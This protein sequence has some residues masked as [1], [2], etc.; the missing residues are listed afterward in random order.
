M[1]YLLA[2]IAT[3]ALLSSA[4]AEQEYGLS[5]P[6]AGAKRTTARIATATER[7]QGV[8]DAAMQ[9]V[10]ADYAAQK[11]RQGSRTEVKTVEEIATTYPGD[12]LQ[13]KIRNYI[14]ECYS[15]KHTVWVMLGGDVDVIPGI[16]MYSHLDVW[17]TDMYYSFLEQDWNEND[18]NRFGELYFSGDTVDYSPEVFVGRIPCSTPPQATAILNKI[19]AYERDTT[20][21]DYQTRALYMGTNVLFMDD[22]FTPEERDSYLMLDEFKE[23][24]PQAFAETRLYA[25]AASQVKTE[26][27]RGY[28]LI[29][30]SCQTQDACSFLTH[31]TT[32]W[33]RER[34]EHTFFA[35]SMSN[36]GK[37]GVFWNLTCYD[38]NLAQE[39]AVA[40]HFMRNPNGGGVA[41]IGSTGFDHSVSLYRSLHFETLRRI[42]EDGITEP[43]KALTLAKSV[44]IPP[45]SFTAT[46]ERLAM[47]TFMYLGDPQMQMWTAT[48]RRLWVN[49]APSVAVTQDLL[50]VQ[51]TSLAG[52][53]SGATVCLSKDTTAYLIGTSDNAG[54]VQ[55]S[56]LNLL[57]PGTASVVASKRGCLT[58]E[59]QVEVHLSCCQDT[60]G[61][62]DCD[63]DDLVTLGDLSVLIDY[64]FI[65]MAPLCCPEEANMD[66]SAD[67]L[68]T[69]GDLTLLIDHL[70]QSLAP[71]PLC[72]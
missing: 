65:T 27:N 48:P 36:A 47:F 46:T 5:E 26:L 19:T 12:S 30:N 67:G 8:T 24:L 23:Y 29:I 40:R 7:T 13:Q 53:V 37:Y 60:T 22:E 34:I 44:L 2:V 57:T 70:F 33:I 62:V 58:M 63:P 28:G 9:N 59:K 71:L 49:V 43:C 55:F 41:Y 38:G 1:R 4:L 69:M 54:N 68:V 39:C 42:F 14:R 3:A 11:T 52:P 6:D 21:T 31:W 25:A 50:N 32:T 66:L 61:N 15:T 17:L 16:Y 45:D 18:N 10:F 20:Y 56:N 64:L 72:P 35:D 51:I